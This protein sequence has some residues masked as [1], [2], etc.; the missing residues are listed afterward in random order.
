MGR[1][2]RFS[3]PSGISVDASGNVYVADMFNNTIRVGIPVGALGIV[4][5]ARSQGNVIHLQGLGV[6]NKVNR[7][8]SSP[9]LRPDSFTTL[10]S[11]TAAADGSV[12]YDDTNAGTKKFYRVAYP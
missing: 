4:N 8:E 9:D 6:P 3:A 5:I 11:I 12:Q 2:A 10:T 7:I 1:D